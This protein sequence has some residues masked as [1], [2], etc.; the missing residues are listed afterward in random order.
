MP[1][2]WRSSTP[3]CRQSPSPTDSSAGGSSGHDQGLVIHCSIR[4]IGNS[5]CPILTKTNYIEWSAVMRIMLQGRH[6]WDT[7]NVGTGEFTDDRNALEAL[8]KAVPPELQG[9]L[10]N[11]A[12][13]KEAWDA[14][15]TRHLGIDRVHKVK[16][17]TLR[18]EFNVITFKEGESIDNFSCRLT[19]ITD[20]LAILGD[21]YEEETIMRKFLHALPEH[22]HQIAVATETL[23]HLEEVSLDELVARLKATEERMDHAK[24]KGGVGLSAG[25][26]EINDKLY[27]TEEQVIAHLASYL[28][29]NTDGSGMHGRA[30]AGPGGAAGGTARTHV[31][32]RVVARSTTTLAATVASPDFGPG[33]ATRKSM[34]RHRPKRASPRPTSLRRRRRHPRCS[35][36]LCN[37]L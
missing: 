20:Q 18:Q 16:A 2:R 21:V 13:A 1:P 27:F 33:S 4:E 17:Q 28:N 32:L 10:A 22:F 35:W 24:A 5:G 37:H 36:Q 34:T 30:Q 12:M 7:V 11:K 29:L 23:L 25:G 15:K 26:K 19:K 6:L 9:V 14:L 3:W 31:Q 8:C